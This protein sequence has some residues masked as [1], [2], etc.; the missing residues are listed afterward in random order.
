MEGGDE[1]PAFE[2]VPEKFSF[3]DA[4][5]EVLDFWTRTR[6]FERSLEQSEAEERP[7]YTFYDGP[8]TSLGVGHCPLPL[9]CVERHET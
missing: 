9:R 6:A 2:A 1:A 7:I 4:E 3:P 5:E 8:R